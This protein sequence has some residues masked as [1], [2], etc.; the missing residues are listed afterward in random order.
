M[1]YEVFS[2]SGLESFCV[3]PCVKYLGGK[4]FYG[5]K[6]LKTVQLTNGVQAIGKSCFA[7]C[8]QLSTIEIPASVMYV[9][10]EAFC[11]CVALKNL[12]VKSHNTEWKEEVF[13]TTRIWR[14]DLRYNPR[15][16]YSNLPDI[17][18]ECYAGATIQS[19]AR[20][21][22]LKCSRLTGIPEKA[23]N[24]EF[25]LNT[26]IGI[27]IWEITKPRSEEHRLLSF[28]SHYDTVITTEYFSFEGSTTPPSKHTDAWLLDGGI[29]KLDALWSWLGYNQGGYH[30]YFKS[31]YDFTS[32]RCIKLSRLLEG[33]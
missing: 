17:N 27:Q 24:V 25:S 7:E 9:G 29:V 22:N 32:S 8:R 2:N 30:Q 33:W 1:E 14:P 6:N 12:V 5:C 10:R 16:I 19:Y 23:P 13:T 26:V 28:L 4:L 11:N 20:E 31:Q 15:T 3:P 18:I 21:H